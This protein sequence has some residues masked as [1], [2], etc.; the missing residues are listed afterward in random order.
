MSDH[1][2]SPEAGRGVSFP[3]ITAVTA[4]VAGGLVY[5]LPGLRGAESTVWGLGLLVSGLPVVFRTLRGALRGRFAADLVASL[6]IVTAFVLGE[7]LVG[8]I[9]VVMQTGGEELERIARRRASEATREL[10]AAAPRIA[11]RYVGERL[12]DVAVS[13]VDIGDVLL[14][15][16]GELIPCD[17]IVVDGR[18]HLDTAAI[19]G[20]PMPMA[21]SRGARVRSGSANQEG[22]LRIQATAL[23]RDSEY[24]TIVEL[25]RTAHEHKAPLQRIADRYAVWFTPATILVATVAYL[26]SGDATRVLAVLVVATP[27]PLILATPVAVIGG[28]NRAAKQRIVMRHGGALEHLGQADVLVLD[29]TGTITVGRPEVSRVV[30]TDSVSES[31]LLRLAAGLEQASSHVLAKS[32]VAAAFA[33]GMVLPRPEEARE[34]AG[35]G[36]TGV[37]ENRQV[38]IGAAS[39]IEALYPDISLAQ[40]GVEA[41][42]SDIARAYVAVDGRPSGFVEYAD[43]LRKDLARMRADVDRLGV[44]RLLLLSG[45]TDGKTQEV[46]TAAGFTDARGGLMASDKAAIVQQMVKAGDRVVMVGDGTNDA[47]ALATATVGVALAGHS[48]GV[49]AAAADVVILGDDLTLVTE[50]MRISRRTMRIARQGIGIG[51]GLSGAGMLLA[52]AGILPPL[53]GA[54]YQ[55]AI[56]LLVILNALR[57][58]R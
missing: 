22:A 50:G 25:V 27:C 52:A 3:L 24:E 29:K 17:G 36:V 2:S 49:A 8:L 42:N 10:E 5:V 46:A 18:S 47:P 51:L 44:K 33:R 26:I 41:G 16:P 14:V 23:A 34:L 54:V 13:E 4:I 6:A 7:P 9:V 56:D 1:G 48:G 32:T 38:A 31:D 37:V 19:T 40:Q 20:E 55:E 45:D 30:A 43:T 15:R 21:V 57:A 53:A 11:H 58:A 39:F 35:R 12:D 28:I